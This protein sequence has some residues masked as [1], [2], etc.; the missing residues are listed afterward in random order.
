MTTLGHAL[1]S[2]SMD[3]RRRS[4]FFSSMACARTVKA[5]P[6]AIPAELTPRL[7]ARAPRALA[8]AKLRRTEWSSFS[9]RP[10][11]LLAP[12]QGVQ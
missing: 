6:G 2:R 7:R 4:R 1:S 10:L 11:T 9:V 5:V 3:P 8:R 12:R